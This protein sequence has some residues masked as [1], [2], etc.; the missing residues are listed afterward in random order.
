MH[1]RARFNYNQPTVA[2]RPFYGASASCTDPDQTPQNAASDQV[3][4][5]LL[6]EYTCTEVWMEL[7]L[8]TYKQHLNSKWISSIAMVGTFD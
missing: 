8:T 4:H 5:S 2:N 1:A 3:L 7:K 6:T